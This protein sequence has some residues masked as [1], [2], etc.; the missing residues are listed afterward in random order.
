MTQPLLSDTVIALRALEPEDLDT[1]YAWEND[2]TI[3]S[4]GRTT[5]PYSRS[6]LQSYIDNYDA[7]IYSARQL[8]LMV[9]EQSSGQAVGAVDLY[10]FDPVNLRAGVGIL[11]DRAFS[12]RGYGRRAVSLI[13]RYSASRLGI[14]QLW[15]VVPA[16]NLPCR[17]LFDSLDYK[18]NGR[19]RSWIKVGPTYTD[20]FLYQHLL[21]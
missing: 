2:T 10:E 12:G 14:H 17:A 8:R 1:L 4:V 13:E 7:D 6:L 20:A 18:I 3:W 19:L 5:A 9:V 15:A 16:D 11:I 21:P